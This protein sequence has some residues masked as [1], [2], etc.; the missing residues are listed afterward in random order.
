MS[1]TY[2][3]SL[4]EISAVCSFRGEKTQSILFLTVLLSAVTVHDKGYVSALKVDFLDFDLKFI[5]NHYVF[6]QFI[7]IYICV[8]VYIYIYSDSIR[9]IT[10]RMHNNIWKY[11]LEKIQQT[12]PKMTLQK[13]KMK[14]KNVTQVSQIPPLII[15]LIS[16]IRFLGQSHPHTQRERE[17]DIHTHIRGLCHYLALWLLWV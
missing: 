13:M 11:F 6:I 2:G 16:V 14:R 17:R 15:V 12:L 9:Y 7:Y 3:Q 10:M 4:R 8:M 1:F 5:M